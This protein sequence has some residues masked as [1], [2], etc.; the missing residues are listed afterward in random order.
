ML[1][2]AKPNLPPSRSPIPTLLHLSLPLPM[3][4]STPPLPISS[5]IGRLCNAAVVG[6]REGDVANVD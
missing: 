1:L 4:P 6:G 2:L 5:A 3:R